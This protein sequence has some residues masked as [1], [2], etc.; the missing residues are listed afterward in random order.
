M[1][2]LPV[3]VGLVLALGAPSVAVA[4]PSVTL[5]PA[6]RPAFSAGQRDYVTRCAAGSVQVTATGTA[7]LPISIDGRPPRSGAQTV[8]VPL[9]AGQRFSFT[10]GRR[11]YDV[12]CLPEEL[13]DL[14]VRGLLPRSMPLVLL[15][16]NR[17]LAPGTPG[18]AVIIDRRGV[19]IWWRKGSPLVAA[20][21]FV[22]HNRIGVWDGALA[23]ADV[24]RGTLQIERPDGSRVRSWSDVDAHEAHL[25]A[26]GSLW[27]ITAAER[28][29]VDLR[30][31]AGPASASTFD[32]VVEQRSPSGRVLWA[33]NAAEHTD[34]L[35]SG[36]WLAPIIALQAR[37]RRLDLQHL[38]S[39]DTDGHGTVLV[40]ACHQDAVY[41]VRR[42]DGAILW[43][44]GGTP[45][46]RSLRIVGDRL[47]PTL[48]GQHD[49]RFQADGTI[50]VFDNGTSL[51]RPSRVTR[52]R[53]D[54]RRRTARLVEAIVEP[55][56]RSN[57]PGGGTRRDS[58]GN[59][60]VAW[61]TGA[62]IRAYDRR[63]RTIFKLDYAQPAISYRA[64]PAAS[65][66]MSRAALIAGMDRRSPR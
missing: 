42:R 41:G 40:S 65:G 32:G 3:V 8:S 33:W 15:S 19:P 24:G 20:A 44:L 53:I 7:D 16:V 26:D 11:S 31:Y 28:R 4:A 1:R 56:A 38:N 58:A 6:L 5:D 13:V 45:T 30:S 37:D 36:R 39:I 43:K 50:T 14:H 22:G 62:R 2:T 47:T 25:A 35:D 17:L 54:A 46:A 23:D 52:W 18:W 34:I 49:A 57:L 55:H 10:V 29:G 12:R 63:H 59:W 61:S 9:R 27:V 64:V 66:Q 21:E 48:G 60:L 51:D